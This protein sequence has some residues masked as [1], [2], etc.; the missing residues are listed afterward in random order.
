MLNKRKVLGKG[1]G[2]LIKAGEGAEK[3]EK[4]GGNYLLCPVGKISA[5]RLQPRKSFEDDQM[6]QLIDSIKESG[7]IEP[8]VARRKG[9]SF[10]LIAGERR[11]RAATAAGLKE[12]PLVV[13]EA[14]DQQSLEF[15]IVENIQRADLNAIEEADAFKSLM[16]FGL[17]QEQVAGKVGKDRAT[18]ANY[19]RLLKLPPEVKDQ[20]RSGAISMGHARAILSLSGHAAQR[21]LCRKVITRGLSVRETEA[22]AAGAGKTK[23]SSG[24]KTLRL[25]PLENELREIFGT[26]VSVKDSG[27]RGKVEIE[28]FSVEE[29]ERIVELLRSAG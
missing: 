29:R 6:M 7:V 17:S 1:L 10:E 2:A 18:V 4:A 9:S 27:G 19:L 14:T 8:L 23:R 25:N 3:G 21:E 22:L 13:M 12:V 11:L 5:N 15:A 26:K 24:A 16:D 28:F 20:L